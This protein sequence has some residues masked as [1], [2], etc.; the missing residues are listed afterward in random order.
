MEGTRKCVFSKTRWAEHK[1]NTMLMI[2]ILNRFIITINNNNSPAH[3]FLDVLLHVW[4]LNNSFMESFCTI[5]FI[6]YV[7]QFVLKTN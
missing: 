4:V 6:Q 3:S 1:L 5:A 2:S 7:F